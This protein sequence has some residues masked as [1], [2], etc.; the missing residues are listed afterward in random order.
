MLEGRGR[1]R[2]SRPSL[3][4]TTLRDGLRLS[5]AAGYLSRHVEG[6][7][8]CPPVDQVRV[9]IVAWTDDVEVFFLVAFSE[10]ARAGLIAVPPRVGE[11]PPHQ[12]PDELPVGVQVV[13]A[14][15]RI[16]FQSLTERIH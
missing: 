4:G 15:L 8:A 11:Q 16:S 3:R 10:P 7:I 13:P 12:V 6:T 1:Q 9:S 5:L 2:L 14:G